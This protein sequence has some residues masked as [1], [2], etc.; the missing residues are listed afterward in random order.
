MDLDIIRKRHR[1]LTLIILVFISIAFIF[2]I[3][4]FVTDFGSYGG[5]TTGSAAEV[6]GEE[7]SLSE[8]YRVRENLRRQYG[9][10]FD[11]LPDTALDFINMSALNQLIDLKLLAQKAR[12]LGFRISNEE[13]AEAI[14]STFQSDGQF[15]GK[16]NYERLIQEQLKEDVG[17]FEESF[18]QQMLAQKLLE[19]I[20]ETIMV[21]DQKLLNLYNIQNEKI[22]LNYIEFSS[23]DFSDPEAPTDEEIEKYYQAQKANFKTDEQ[24]KIRYIILEPKTFENN[25]QISDEELRAYYNAYP[26]EFQSEE[27]ETIPYEEA[28]SEVESKLK[29]QKAQVIQQDFLENFQSPES[30][31]ISIDQ[32]A[33]DTSTDSINESPL[34]S[35][36]DPASDIPPQV[37]N[38]TFSELQGN[39]VLV[40]VGTSTWVVEVSEVS[41]PR[42]K[43]LDEAKTDVV[44]ALNNQKATTKAR[45]KANQTLSKLKSTNKDEISSKAQE[46]GVSLQETGAFTRTETVPKINLEQ[47]K[48]QAFEIDEEGTVLSRVYQNNNNYYVIILKEKFSANPAEFELKKEELKEIE[49]QTQRSDLMQKWIQNLRREAKIEV[50]DSLFPAQG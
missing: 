9:Q 41:E 34:F 18:K 13:L 19:F 50:N 35:R 27:G 3:G 16:A 1:W 17:T 46:L 48:S 44:T 22:N 4:S 42:E 25:I 15:I 33:A 20:D 6:N 24:R 37:V 5:R 26:E 14:R 39:T 11:Q 8:Y 21:T 43:N 36:S 47:V 28:K 31:G 38:R 40:P 49:L 12:E 7:I 30:P 10:Q 23:K 32:I 29:G 45:A 2:G